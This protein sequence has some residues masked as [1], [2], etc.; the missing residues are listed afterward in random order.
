MVDGSDCRFSDITCV[1]DSPSLSE[2]S[3]DG[4]PLAN[5]TE[6][7]VVMVHRVAGLRVLDTKPISVSVCR[8]SLL[9]SPA[10]NYNFGMTAFTLTMPF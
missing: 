2:L 7:R 6:Y 3:L 9:H 1:T 10:A 5:N 4:N 8:S